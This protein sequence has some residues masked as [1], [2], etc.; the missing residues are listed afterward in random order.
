MV[1]RLAPGVNRHRLPAVA[2]PAGRPSVFVASLLA[3]MLF[4]NGRLAAQDD[5]AAIQVAPADRSVS[6]VSPRAPRTW[7]TSQID[8][9]SV[10]GQ[11]M[12]ARSGATHYTGT[13]QVFRYETVDPG[14]LGLQ[15]SLHLP[16]GARVLT[17]QLDY[18]DTSLSG[19]VLAE[20]DDC[21]YDGTSCT[22]L[23]GIPACS[24]ALVT[25]CSGVVNAPGWSSVA[26]DLSSANLVIDNFLHGYR[27]LAGNTSYDG[28]T[29][30]WR[31]LVGYVLQV[32]PDPPY[33]D[34]LDVP[35]SHVFHQYVE[36][37]YASRITAGCGGGNY[38][39]DAPLTR[40]QMAVFL[41]KA[42][43]LQWH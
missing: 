31:V 4:A 37:L 42:L 38:C 5:P 6:T 25:L 15:A 23:F 2:S 3:A 10:S 16:S 17:L 9:Y 8:Y 24:D 39:P 29:A 21:G 22:P 43:G 36:A 33:A 26:T 12:N 30:I 18:Y 7:G 32:S 1:M 13:G 14:G 11:E 40:G 27:I 20:L 35:T 28:S 19:E 41:S 34:F